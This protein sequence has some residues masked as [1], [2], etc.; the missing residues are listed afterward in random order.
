MR[1]TTATSEPLFID[2]GGR[3]LCPAHLGVYAASELRRRP[4]ARMLQTPL[5]TWVRVDRADVDPD[6]WAVVS[7]ESCGTA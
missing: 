7:C 6:E 3:T 4:N 2:D 1:S 5:G